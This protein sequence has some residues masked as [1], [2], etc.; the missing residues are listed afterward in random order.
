M[1]KQTVD[2]T[3]EER[4]QLGPFQRDVLLGYRH[5]FNNV[6]STE[7]LVGAIVD[8]E[9]PSEV[10]GNINFSHRLTDNWVMRGSGRLIF[11]SEEDSP[12]YSL[13][14]AH[15]LQLSLVRYF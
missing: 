11:A 3:E 14:E 6:E 8:L 1:N 4:Q 12:L 5:A 10:L 9:D 2:A 7:L 15:S 13:D